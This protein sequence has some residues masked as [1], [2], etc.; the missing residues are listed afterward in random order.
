MTEL[1]RKQLQLQ[2]R[3]KE[4]QIE[5]KFREYF[6]TTDRFYPESVIAIECADEKRK[7]G[8]RVSDDRQCIC[9][10]QKRII[11]FER[12]KGF[13]CRRWN[14]ETMVIADGCKCFK[15]V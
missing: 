5:L 9:K 12:R 8:Y 2:N 14:F 10:T 15:T 6:K 3:C 13:D 1:V 11:H 7:D 4:K